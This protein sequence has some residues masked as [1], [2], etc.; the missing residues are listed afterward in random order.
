MTLNL[1]GWLLSVLSMQ[2][3]VWCYPS[4]VRNFENFPIDLSRAI[5]FNHTTCDSYIYYRTGAESEV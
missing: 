2:S 5:A 3:F 1:T 4:E